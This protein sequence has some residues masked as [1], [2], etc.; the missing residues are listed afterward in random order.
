MVHLVDGHWDAFP[1]LVYKMTPCL[2]GMYQDSV[3]QYSVIAACFLFLTAARV[4]VCF[5]DSKLLYF[6]DEQ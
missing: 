3:V 1:F 2:I 4:V 5:R 6:R